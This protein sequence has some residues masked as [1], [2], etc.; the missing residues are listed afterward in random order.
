MLP[1]LLWRDASGTVGLLSDVDGPLTAVHP[2]HLYERGALSRWQAEDDPMASVI[3][4][5]VLLLAED[6]HITDP[7]I[8]SQLPPGLNRA[9]TH[10]PSAGEMRPADGDETASVRRRRRTRRCRPCP[11]PGS[12]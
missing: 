6:E 4:S 3:L 12:W 5:K 9:T 8:L 2:H 11:G 1:A 7:S 10:G